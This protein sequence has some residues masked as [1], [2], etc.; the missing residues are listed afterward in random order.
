MYILNVAVSTK[1]AWFMYYYSPEAGYARAWSDNWPP[2][3]DE[4]DLGRR[5]RLYHLGDK[6]THLNVGPFE[7]RERFFMKGIE[8]HGKELVRYPRY[9]NLPPEC[10]DAIQECLTSEGWKLGCPRFITFG[11]DDSW[12]IGYE[13]GFDWSKSINPQLNRRLKEGKDKGWTINASITHLFTLSEHILKGKTRK[14]F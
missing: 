6:L 12:I 11:G 10:E 4:G 13:R 7:G 9:G 3:R 14:P 1:E 8:Q 2:S 5:L